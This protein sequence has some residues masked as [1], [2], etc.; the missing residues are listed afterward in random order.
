MLL[1]H[2]LHL[3]KPAAPRVETGR[4]MAECPEAMLEAQA[5][6]AVDLRLPTAELTFR[7]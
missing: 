5:Q 4:P 1:T 2:A 7:L 3:R 6:Q